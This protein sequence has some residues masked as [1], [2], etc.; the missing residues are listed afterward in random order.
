[1]AIGMLSRNLGPQKQSALAALA[2]S[3]GWK[4]IKEDLFADAVRQAQNDMVGIDPDDPNYEKKV[5]SAQRYAK[6]ISDVT[7]VLIR[8]IEVHAGAFAENE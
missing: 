3:Y 1:M 4:V 5:A 7:Q 6:S 2:A 8:S